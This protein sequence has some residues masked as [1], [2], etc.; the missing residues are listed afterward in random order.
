M[1]YTFQ[2]LQKRSPARV[3][4]HVRNTMSGIFTT[5]PTSTSRLKQ[6]SRQKSQS[7]WPSHRHR[8]QDRHEVP[9]DRCAL[10]KKRYEQYR[11]WRPRPSRRKQLCVRTKTAVQAR[12]GSHWIDWM[13]RTRFGDSY[14]KAWWVRIERGAYFDER[15]GDLGPTRI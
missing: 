14:C 13:R 8:P 10:R 9:D 6:C 3:H 12:I 5:S 4:I 2:R 15:C 11:P 1:I 7:M